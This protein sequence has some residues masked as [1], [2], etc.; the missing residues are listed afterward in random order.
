[1]PALLQLVASQSQEQGE[2]Y[3]LLADAEKEMLN[4]RDKQKSVTRKGMIKVCHCW[5]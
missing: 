1:M 2:M 3:P 4:Q 5:V